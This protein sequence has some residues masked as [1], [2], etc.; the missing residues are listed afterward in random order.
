MVLQSYFG[1]ILNSVEFRDIS[2]D[3]SQTLRVRVL[4]ARLGRAFV[5]F[6][7]LSVKKST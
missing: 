2:T 1:V 4:I 6:C 3:N 5:D 7:D